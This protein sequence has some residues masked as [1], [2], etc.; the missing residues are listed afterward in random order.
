MSV[1]ANWLKDSFSVK[2]FF[3]GLAVIIL[4]YAVIIAWIVLNGD[5]VVSNQQNQLSSKTVLINRI[6]PLPKPV[7][8]NESKKEPS[9][10]KTL[11]N[12]EKTYLKPSP[13]IDG[14][15]K[16]L[17]SG[18]N[19]APIEGLHKRN[20]DG[21]MPVIRKDKLTAFHAYRA[22]FNKNLIDAPIISIGIMNLGLSDTATESAIK[23]M[24]DEV[25][26]I[27]SP[28]AKAAEFWINEARKKGHEIWFSLPVETEDYP[29]YDPGP[30]TLLVN[31]PE[32]DNM[33]KL[34]WLMSRATGYVGFVTE[35]EPT[36]MKAIQD[37]RPVINKI[38]NHGLAFVDG[39]KEPGMIPQSLA[40]G[41]NA[42]YATIDVWIDTKP[43]RGDIQ[44]SL[45]ELERVAKER[46]LA[47][48]VISAYPL[49]FQEIQDWLESLSQKGFALAPLSAQTGI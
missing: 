5:K 7:E 27:L 16:K 44:K 39:S 42:P 35:R 20:D 14:N 10:D 46:G 6:K 25:S 9:G 13:E 43:S 28:Y 49:S 11:E 34:D 29:L 22:P 15:I 26:L 19:V 48:G 37:M 1:S 3:N 21:L 2:T 24:P 31:A 32:R 30:H 12:L 18:L 45:K 38:Y 8:T 17:E 33:K 23:N 36:F 4:I 47:A 41:M 40:H